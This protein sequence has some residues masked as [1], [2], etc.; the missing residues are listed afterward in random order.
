MSDAVQ[1]STSGGGL[2]RLAKLMNNGP[3][4]I[5]NSFKSACLLAEKVIKTKY[6]TVQDGALLFIDKQG[7]R[8][9]TKR[10]HYPGVRTSTGTL[11]RSVSTQF[12]AN[13]GMN[14][15]ASIG[16]NIEYG[17]RLNENVKFTFLKPGV[18][19]ALPQMKQLMDNQIKVILK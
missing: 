15:E 6:M 12:R 9:Y 4:Q 11:K 7:G 17:Q 10:S 3:A 8:H 1:I 16:T 2:D 14:L 19:D 5:V 18:E 13:F